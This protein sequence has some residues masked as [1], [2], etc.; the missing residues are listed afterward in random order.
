MPPRFFCLASRQAA[1]KITRLYDSAAGI[2]IG[3]PVHYPSQL[4]LRG[5]MPVGSWPAFW[6]ERTTLRQS[7]LLERRNG[8]TRSA[9]PAR[10]DCHHAQGRA[11]CA[12]AFYWARRSGGRQAAGPTPAALKVLGSRNLG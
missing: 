4:M 11:M 9:D 2:G 6:K 1:R 10:H 3:P 7:S 12:A 5:E 8:F